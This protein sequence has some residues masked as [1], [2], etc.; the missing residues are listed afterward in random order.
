ML[1]TSTF[2]LDLVAFEKR[3]PEWEDLDT[4][5]LMG[6]SQ[7]KWEWELFNAGKQAACIDN[8]P[9]AI[10]PRWYAEIIPFGCI[11]NYSN[12]SS[13][14]CFY[15][16]PTAWKS[17][18]GR[19]GGRHWTDGE[20]VVIEGGPKWQTVRNGDGFGFVF[21]RSHSNDSTFHPT[22]PNEGCAKL[23][24]FRRLLELRSHPP[25]KAIIQH[26]GGYILE[27]QTSRVL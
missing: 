19:S 2:R 5:K 20:G 18:T 13:Q 21:N 23:T 9:S 1:L 8:S 4:Y 16:L 15:P 26:C 17:S 22:W 24:I 6:S 14:R 3:V 7:K 11:G 25:Q 27:S 12:H 10:T